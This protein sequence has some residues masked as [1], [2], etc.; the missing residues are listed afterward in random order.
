MHDTLKRRPGLFALRTSHV[1]LAA[2]LAAFFALFSHLPVWHTD[3][4][5]HMRFGQ[6]I[7][8]NRALPEHE[9]F[10]ESEGFA[11]KAA[12]Y[13]NYQ[14]IA[15]AG[16]YLIYEAGAAL[17]PADDDHRLGGGALF[18]VVTHDL[19]LVLRFVILYFAFRR[20]SGS[21]PVAVLGVAAVCVMGMLVHLP[22]IRP[23]VIGELA[24]AA[25]LLPLSRPVLSRRALL[26]VPLVFLIW[27]NCHG[28]FAIGF[29]LL[30]AVTA[31]RAVEVVW[32]ARSG[33]LPDPRAALR[34]LWGDVQFRRLVLVTALSV[35]A[36]AIN[37]HGPYLLLNSYTLSKNPNI[38]SM[39]EWK[40][41]PI[42]SG[43]HLVFVISVVVLAVLLRLSPRRFSPA[44][45]LLLLGFGLQSVA[46]ARM[47]VWWIMV[48]AWVAV[49]HA[50]A[51]LGRLPGRH[52]W[53]DDASR[54]STL[55]GLLA[56]GLVLVLLVGSRPAWW[57]LWGD[58][59]TAEGRV[60]IVTPIHVID[61]IH[62]VDAT[63]DLAARL[64]ADRPLEAVAA[65]RVGP[66]PHVLFASETI[67]DYLLWELG[68]RPEHP[69]WRL[70]CYTHV[71]L[72]PA[73]QWQRCIVVK[74]AAPGWQKVLDEWGV[75]F[76]VLE[77]T[78]YD[79]EGRKKRGL[80]PG[81]FGLIDRVREAPDRWL[82]L[83]E[84]DAPVFLA[85]RIR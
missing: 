33:R 74:N 37:P 10:P 28:S 9:P 32:G 47:V 81:I 59:P 71:H 12:Q 75:D 78:L 13:V 76:L 54:P 58:A 38:A 82:V 16:A 26:L 73:E 55:K 60:A 23:Q 7:V 84:P 67:A 35:L 79:Q 46:H 25:V 56:V 17:S 85:Q 6:E 70:C 36:T 64:A 15:Q 8:R 27:A 20:L 61:Q 62:T 11:D 41:L 19:L 42:D 43:V 69:P 83:S 5:A 1:V 77:D 49:P 22:I 66:R 34:A 4:W 50:R 3:I 53:L 45:V 24:F 18:L 14:W 2:L 40:A 30:G 68:Q 48:F 44:Q 63:R 29:I 65:D 57:L 39:E 80:S 51:A 21:P 72:F 52:P 31:G